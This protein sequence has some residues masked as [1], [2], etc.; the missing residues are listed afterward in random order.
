MLPRRFPI[1]GLLV[2]IAIAALG[3]A[4]LANP[5]LWWAVLI[6]Y[7][8]FAVLLGTIVGVLVTRG[9]SRHFWIGA[10]VLGWALAFHPYWERLDTSTGIILTTVVQ[11]LANLTHPFRAS[12][13]AISNAQQYDYESQ[14]HNLLIEYFT[15]IGCHLLILGFALLGGVTARVLAARSDRQAR[16]REE[17]GAV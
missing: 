8:T 1:V 15:S 11:D 7:L 9:P 12:Q 5:S 6:S 3:M 10:A 13:A 17:P 14:R 16:A 4:A 2:L